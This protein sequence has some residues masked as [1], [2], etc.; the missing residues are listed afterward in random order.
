LNSAETMQLTFYLQDQD[1][2]FGVIKDFDDLLSFINTSTHFTLAKN[3]YLFFAEWKNNEQVLK[4]KFPNDYQLITGRNKKELDDELFKSIGNMLVLNPSPD[5][6]EISD[7]AIDS[8]PVPVITGSKFLNLLSSDVFYRHVANDSIL[9]FDQGSIPLSVPNLFLNNRLSGGRTLVIT[10]N[11]YGQRTITYNISLLKFKSFFETDFTNFIGMERNEP[12]L[13]EGTL[14][15]YH[16]YFN[17]IHMLHFKTNSSEIFS[18][19]GNI[20]ADFYS[21]IPLHNVSDLFKDF[22]PEKTDQRIDININKP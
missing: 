11:L 7:R 3:N 15:I 5:K 12:D 9:V 2:R 1:L 22:K 13:I 18:N 20:M 17:F 14:V 10:Q 16:K 21:N 4:L 8:F 6:T 19:S